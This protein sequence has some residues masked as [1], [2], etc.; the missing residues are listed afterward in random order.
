MREASA[1]VKAFPM[2]SGPV[3]LPSA[4]AVPIPAVT[5]TTSRDVFW[6]GVKAT[7]VSSGL[8]EAFGV[9]AGGGAGRGAG[10]IISPLRVTIAPR[11]TSSL[12]SNPKD[13]SWGAMDSKNFTMLFEYKVEDCV[14]SLDGR[15][16]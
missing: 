4:R 6:K 14:G 15:S 9:G 5:P 13:L 2:K 10:G 16:V 12:R 11:T 3:S 1:K 7:A 8:R